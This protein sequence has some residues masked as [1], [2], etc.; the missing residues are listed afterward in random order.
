MPNHPH[1]AAAT[2][3]TRRRLGSASATAPPSPSSHNRVGNEKNAHGCDLFVRFTHN[4][5]DAVM[6]AATV[7]ITDWREN[8]LRRL[9][10]PDR[11]H[12]SEEAR[13]SAGHTR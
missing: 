3:G 9:D 2:F 5:N 8:R 10:R 13:R 1:S 12:T 6:T 7:T 11:R 4:T